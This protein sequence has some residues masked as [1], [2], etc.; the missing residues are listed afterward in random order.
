MYY[1]ADMEEAIRNKISNDMLVNRI[2][3]FYGDC[4]RRE[5]TQR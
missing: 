2:L 3:N 5:E 4:R 1:L